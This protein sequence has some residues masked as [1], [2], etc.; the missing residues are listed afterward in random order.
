EGFLTTEGT[1][2]EKLM[3]AMQ[4]AKIQGADSRCLEFGTSSLSSFLRVA[5]SDTA[6]NCT[7][8]NI[9]VPEVAE[10]VEPID[11]LQDAF[12]EALATTA[13]IDAPNNHCATATSLPLDT[14][15]ANCTLT[16]G[17]FTGANASITPIT[18]CDSQVGTTDL[19]YNFTTNADLPRNGI[20]I[21]AEFDASTNSSD[22]SNV[23][24]AVY[25]SCDASAFYATCMS[26]DAGNNALLLPSSCIAPE[27][28]YWVRIW[29]R[30]S[31]E[32]NTFRICA[33]EDTNGLS[34][35]E[36]LW[37][38][39]VGEGDFS[40]GLNEWTTTGLLA[41]T[42]LWEWDEKSRAIGAFTVSVLES[43]TRCNGAALFNAD[44]LTSGGDADAV[45]QPYPIHAGELIS[46][47]ID[48][49]NALAPAIQ[50]TQ[51]FRGLNG[52]NNTGVNTQRGA[53]LSYSLDG[54]Q[55]WNTPT[56]INDNLDFNEFSPN[57]DI[58]TI[59]MG[60]AAG[61]S[62]FRMKFIFDGD[63]YFWIVDDVMIIDNAV[64]SGVDE[65]ILVETTPFK[66]AV[67]NNLV[68]N[69]LVLDI[70][71][72]ADAQTEQAILAIYHI[73]GQQIHQV[74]IDLSAQESFSYAYDMGGLASGMYLVQV[75][76]A[77]GV[78]KVVRVV[79]N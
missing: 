3:G 12:D 45:S 23:G 44:K 32:E 67:R 66:I 47:I 5:C 1:L 49:S 68:Q 6:T 35:K 57:T 76:L 4:G 48:L 33:F 2:A 34:S 31:N 54:G 14:D 65:E 74:N 19:W 43:R 62:E 27:T 25:E 38:E 21:A 29:S 69:D 55:T 39:N 60:D 10:G 24:I 52:S 42:D 50:F 16:E 70:E 30:L 40:G 75:E 26:S 58:K 79:K 63:F 37:G 59:P 77:N 15:L 72:N 78:R 46:P 9:V 13:S 18:F 61:A 56:I 20:F 28:T 73:N 7:D 64:I 22:I 41:D 17:D 51:L 36:V 8:I 71:L 11:V 53:L